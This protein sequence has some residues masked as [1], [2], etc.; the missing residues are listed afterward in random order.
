MIFN[1][2]ENVLEASHLPGYL[3]IYISKILSYLEKELIL[4]RNLKWFL[5]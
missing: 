5:L 1:F 2:L 3:Q 4:E